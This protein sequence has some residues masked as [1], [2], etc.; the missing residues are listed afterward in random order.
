M[1]NEKIPKKPVRKEPPETLGGNNLRRE[2][3]G[4]PTGLSDPEQPQP[5]PKQGGDTP[6]TDEEASVTI[7]PGNN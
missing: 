4:C 1:S 3:A 6:T 5:S 7:I 2:V